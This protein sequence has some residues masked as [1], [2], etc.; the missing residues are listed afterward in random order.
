MK[1][2]F[3]IIGD[4]TRTC[5]VKNYSVLSGTWLPNFSTPIKNNARYK[6]WTY[7]NKLILIYNA[8]SKI[9][10]YNKN[11]FNIPLCQLSY[12][13]FVINN[14]F[15]LLITVIIFYTFVIKYLP[16]NVLPLFLYLHNVDSPISK[17][18]AACVLSTN[19]FLVFGVFPKKELFF[20][21]RILI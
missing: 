20:L 4:K 3:H 15:I 12:P 16:W 10:T 5:K 2:F 11:I 18:L 7:L 14:I 17:Y 19:N 13:C 1:N 8:R 9:W 6:T 21:L